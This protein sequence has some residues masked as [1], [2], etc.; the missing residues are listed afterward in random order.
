M[1]GSMRV[2]VALI[3]FELRT[4]RGFQSL[5][6]GMLN[7]PAPPG[8]QYRTFERRRRELP[9]RDPFRNEAY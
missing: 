7:A 2:P 8:F 4:V 9:I 1:V 6:G 5:K 3:V